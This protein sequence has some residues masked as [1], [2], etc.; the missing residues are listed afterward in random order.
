MRVFTG[1]RYLLRA[2]DVLPVDAAGKAGEQ[3]APLGVGADDP[4]QPRRAA[5]RGDVV[6][7]VARAAGHHRRR[8]VFEDQHRRLARDARHL[9]V[10]EFVGDEIT[11]DQHAAAAEAVDEPEQ[12]FLALGFTGQR[13]D[14][15]G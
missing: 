3:P 4:C 2:N 6:G 5:E 15:S 11:D 9:P 1:V 8:V 13:V 7:G 10:D 14:G 12:T